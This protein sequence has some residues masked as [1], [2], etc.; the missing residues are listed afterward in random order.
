M[1]T[2]RRFGL[3]LGSLRLI[4]LRT[5]AKGR[6]WRIEIAHNRTGQTSRCLPPKSKPRTQ[7]FFCTERYIKSPPYI[8]CVLMR[9]E[10]GLASTVPVLE[11]LAPWQN[12][13]LSDGACPHIVRKNDKSSHRR[14]T[15]SS[16]RRSSEARHLVT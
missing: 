8:W 2:Y 15:L 16:V 10:H 6:R 4:P 12:G 11:S 7:V 14:E 9:I 3:P 13:C 5:R 1:S